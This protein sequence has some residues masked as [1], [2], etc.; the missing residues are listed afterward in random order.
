VVVAA[1]ESF[2]EFV[3]ARGAAL[4]RFAYLLAR[5][6]GQAED[7]VQEALL[8]ANRRWER[9]VRAD[10]PEAYVRRIVV[11]DFLSWRRRRSST[12]VTGA[13]PETAVS[14]AADGVA[15]R[16]LL[17]RAL[18]TLPA[19]Q[20]A[21]LVLRYY[22]DLTDPQI[23]DVLGC[24]LGTVRSLTTRALAALRTDQAWAGDQPWTVT[25]EEP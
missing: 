24:A 13:V 5:D 9:V 3:L 7:L 14:D 16:D 20:R 17:W 19:R 12:E 8:K 23:A 22:E 10:R 6:A 25:V 15:E 2:D 18:A 1:V 21:V 11:N 4:L